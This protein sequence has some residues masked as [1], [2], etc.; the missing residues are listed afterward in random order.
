MNFLE[1]RCFKHDLLLKGGAFIEL[2]PSGR[3][4]PGGTSGHVTVRKGQSI[5]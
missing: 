2:T 1:K 5:G 3:V 4:P